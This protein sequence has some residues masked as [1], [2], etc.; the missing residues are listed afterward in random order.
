MGCKKGHPAPVWFELKRGWPGQQGEAFHFRRRRLC[1][2]AQTTVGAS[3]S[4]PAAPA[5][6]ATRAA[7]GGG[8]TDRRRN[9]GPWC[10]SCSGRTSSR[11]RRPW[12][13]RCACGWAPVHVTMGTGTD[14]WQSEGK[15]TLV[16]S[17]RPL[18]AASVAQCR[19]HCEAALGQHDQTR[20]CLCGTWSAPPRY[21]HVMDRAHARGNPGKWRS[22]KPGMTGGYLRPRHERGLS[23]M[24]GAVSARCWR[25]VLARFSARTM[26]V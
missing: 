3:L 21:T 14:E 17:A 16:R 13:C 22:G 11:S 9:T 7:V 20:L 25:V 10:R 12:R 18:R 23:A 1:A 5:S 4:R 15:K 8:S 2:V 24:P 19:P 26:S 6:Y